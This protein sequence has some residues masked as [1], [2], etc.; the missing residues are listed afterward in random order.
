MTTSLTAVAVLDAAAVSDTTA[1]VSVMVVPP[2]VN[3]VVKPP[4]IEVVMIPFEAHELVLPHMT[5]DETYPP[6][7]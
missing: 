7:T 4:D 2:A 5:V 6:T 3:A 1:S